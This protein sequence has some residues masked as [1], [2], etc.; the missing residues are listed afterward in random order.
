LKIGSFLIASIVS[1]DAWKPH[2]ATRA[3]SH[4]LAS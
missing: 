3:R 1:G 4:T 2:M